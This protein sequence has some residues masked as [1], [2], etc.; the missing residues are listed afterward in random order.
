VTITVNGV[1]T[2][3]ANQVLTFA[4]PPDSTLLYGV[5][6]LQG[7]A[8]LNI[9]GSVSIQYGFSNITSAAIVVDGGTS[10]HIGTGGSVTVSAPEAGEGAWGFFDDYV[11]M[12]F[13]N[14]GTFAVSSGANTYAIQLRAGGVVS[15]TGTITAAVSS[16]SSTGLYVSDYSGS[17]TTFLNTGTITADTAIGTGYG[18]ML[19]TNSGAIHGLVDYFS[20]SGQD[21]YDG[22][23]G[24]Q[25]GGILFNG[26]GGVDTVYLGNDGETV[27]GG[28]G[29]LIATGGSGADTITGGSANDTIDGG[30]GND[31][32]DGGGGVNTVSFA[33]ATTGV[34]VSLALQGSA[35]V[36]GV[37]S[38]T[39]SNFQNLTGSAYN[40]VLTG[41][42]NNNVIDGGGGNDVLTGGGGSDTFVIGPNGGSDTITDFTVSGAQ[43][44]KIDLSSLYKYLS[45]AQILTAATQ[46]AADTVFDLGGGRS[47]TLQNVQKGDL[48]ASDFIFPTV[49]F[50]VSGGATLTTDP[51]LVLTVSTGPLV[52]FTD[53]IGGRFVNKGSLT[54]SGPS[55]SHFGVA[56][57][58]SGPQASA[59]FENDGSFS[60]NTA[61][62]T[63]VSFATTYNYGTFFVTGA[64]GT[65]GANGDFIN[66]GSVTV[67]GSPPAPG[68]VYGVYD[69]AYLFQNMAGATFQTSYLASGQPGNAVGV[70]MINGGQFTNA[71]ALSVSATSDAKGLQVSTNV[72]T[73]IVNSGTI[74]ATGLTSTGI[75]VINPNSPSFAVSLQNS[76]T[77]TAQL[78]I[79]FGGALDASITNSGTINGVVALGGGQNQVVNTGVIN[80]SFIPV[81]GAVDATI[82]NSGTISGAIVL[83]NGN[84]HIVNTGV[85]G[86]GLTLG[87]GASDSFDSHLGTI[88][89]T[90]T[91]GIGTSTVTLGAEDNIVALA[92]GTHVVDGGGGT[93][94]VSYASASSG[95]TVSLAALGT[96]QYTGI[97]ADTLSN[98]QKLIGSGFNDTLTASNGTSTLTGG[99]GA[100]T[101]KVLSGGAN[102]TITDFS[103]A[104]G[105]KID[106]SAL[107]QFSSLTDV[108][109]ASG[110]VGSNTVIAL[111]SGFLTLNNVQKNSLTA[112]D[113]V[114]GGTGHGLHINITYDAS[115]N[116]APAGFRT[117]VQAA[118]D[119]FQNNFAGN[120]T[121]NIAVGWGEVDG[122]AMG[123]GAV[124]ESTSFNGARL[125]YA[126]VLN[127]LAAADAGNPVAAAAIAALPASDPIGGV[128]FLVHT[129]E[130]K[131]LGLLNPNA[132]AI[133]GYI[134]LSSS[135]SFTFDP[136]NRAVGGAYDAIGTIE[137]EISEVLGRRA[138]VGELVSGVP[139]EAPIDLFRYSSP[140]VHSWQAG[141]GFFSLDGVNPYKYFND[142]TTNSGDAGDW[143]TTTQI[144]A[145]DA[146][147]HIGAEADASAADAILMNV[148]GYNYAWSSPY[149]PSPTYPYGGVQTAP[150][151]GGTLYGGTAG[152]W[153][154][155]GPGN[156]ILHGGPGF[157]HLD[158]GGGINTALYD[159][160][161]HQYG[162][163]AGYTQ[164]IG[165]PE[166]GTDTLANIQRIQF[167]DGYLAFA[168]TDTAGQV[169]RLYEGTLGRAPDPA[170][171]AAWTHGLNAGVTLLSVAG[172]LVGSAEFQGTYGALTD[173]GFVSLLYNNVLHRAA[174]A[175]GLA[176][177]TGLLA[178]GHSRAEVVLGFTESN[179]DIA[180]LA[181]PVQQGLWVQDAAAAQVARLYDTAFSRLPDA[182]G[183]AYWTHALESGTTLLQV[184]QG[185][186]ASA[187][188]QG[189][190]GA[191][192]NAGFVSLLYNNV[193]HRAPDAGGLAYWVSLLNT[194]QDSR[195]QEVVGFSESAEHVGNT[196][197][198][199]DQG[200]WLA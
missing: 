148:L 66:Y 121:I 166:G 73:T 4:D 143:A 27:T 43:A 177:W 15:N 164:V 80:G 45:F 9:L 162:F 13:S 48:L 198:H 52:Q 91:V 71:G 170:G 35:Q 44:D 155:G 195:A 102:T 87:N 17:T 89:G 184:A 132:S 172:S 100:D 129:A 25:T 97:S 168:P 117:A 54:L 86:G 69:S 103:H 191:L 131:V 68:T 28:A 19:L 163:G 173:S 11:S 18:D 133:D 197:P 75:A 182:T 32:L 65:V 186:I 171:L 22:R 122:T 108:L 61:L 146:Y 62:G 26:S 31:I 138:H 50:Q 64:L 165:G 16:G 187:E 113:F 49:P 156:D 10:F 150:A 125:S 51:S 81:N 199:I 95:V 104:Q 109:A 38:V 141:P 79:A 161:L 189:P 110:Q 190:Y 153:L 96:V 115:A 60:V 130:E 21:L 56:T 88:N 6:D 152:D 135:T 47:L 183:L 34:T 200:I 147:G 74:T 46:S 20:S 142:S 144:D 167:V 63:G 180:D 24:T 14:D 179:E 157:D 176:Y 40:D 105:D 145:Y 92:A 23:G 169:Y 57:I 120:A 185:F 140:N 55:D 192:D 8:Q 37:G 139:A 42:A 94:T 178:A 70:N 76:G 99:G 3:G 98:F 124:G 30:G 151:G 93:N 33:S 181:T 134:G 106:L 59:V 82:N 154:Q 67:Q 5:Y 194:G 116:A 36:T 111:G 12:S 41:D 159:G 77:I 58:A 1:Y 127:A 123:A 72:A 137:H 118:V 196:A 175:G 7:S 29:T 193:L 160:A 114:L 107:T 126:T 136:N 128:T 112:A 174:D 84:N 78:A 2:V 158:G 119:Y 149:N 53:A 90:V 39:L 188:F 83:G 85:I 101:F